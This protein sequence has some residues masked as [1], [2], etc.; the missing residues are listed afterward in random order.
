VTTTR[1]CVCVL[2]LVLLFLAVGVGSLPSREAGA[3]E[4]LP[5]L[6]IFFDHGL[7]VQTMGDPAWADPLAGADQ[8]RMEACGC[9]EGVISTRARFKTH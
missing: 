6:P 2:A 9:H 3:Q 4:S 5:L 1:R 7:T 8:E